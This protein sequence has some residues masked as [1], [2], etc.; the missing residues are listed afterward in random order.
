MQRSLDKFVIPEMKFVGFVFFMEPVPALDVSLILLSIPLLFLFHCP[1]LFVYPPACLGVFTLMSFNLSH[2]EVSHRMLIYKACIELMD[3][4]NW[5]WAS[6]F[7]S[8]CSSANQILC[9]LLRTRWLASPLKFMSELLISFSGQNGRAEV[10]AWKSSGHGMM[11]FLSCRKHQ[12]IL[13]GVPKAC[14]PSLP[15]DCA[16]T[17]LL[18][19]W[20][21]RDCAP[22]IEAGMGAIPWLYCRALWLLLLKPEQNVRLTAGGK[23]LHHADF[24][25]IHFHPKQTTPLFRQL[26]ACVNALL[27]SRLWDED[28]IE[29]VRCHRVLVAQP[30]VASSHAALAAAGNHARGESPRSGVCARAWAE[31]GCCQK[32]AMFCPL[33]VELPGSLLLEPGLP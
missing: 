3:A 28:G 8:P 9:N 27:G 19:F 24:L 14:Q 30:C 5:L 21:S 10:P 1:L 4:L 22:S 16:L 7:I 25:E 32:G 15:Q 2:V 29:T 23:L 6:L 12:C 11:L 13:W 26:W 31:Q 17:E 20:S 33:H 18:M